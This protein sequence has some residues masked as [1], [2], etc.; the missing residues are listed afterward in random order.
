[1]VGSE[2]TRNQDVSDCWKKM[3]NSKA[4]GGMGFR[5]LQAFNLAMLAKQ[6]WRILSN[7]NS[8]VARVLKDRYVPMSYVLNA[9]LG[10]SLSYSWR[11]I[12][13]HHS[14]LEVIR[15]GTRWRVG[16][17]KLIHIW[18]DKWLPTPSTYKVISPPNNNPEFPMVS[19][20]ID[21]TTKWWKVDMLRATFLLF[22]AKTILR[23][24]LS[25]N[26]PEDKII[27]LGNSCG[28]FTVK[29][30]YH[31]AHKL[32]EAKDEG[33]C[34]SRDPY[35]PLWKKL[36]HLN[37][38]AKVKIFA[39]RVCVNELPTKENINIRGINNSKDCPIYGIKPENTTHA[40]LNC[41]FTTFVW[42][43]W[44]ENPLS[45]QNDELTF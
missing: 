2:A 31:I 1:M 40:L 24:P 33:E 11:S 23:I 45:T 32:V 15:K 9:K 35:K 21:P 28:K 37:I 13:K 19:S 7:P 10:N 14:S 44:L 5:N 27:W 43:M 6:V 3:C 34:S 12:H 42:K 36:W 25:H 22:E 20:L 26:L 8:L 38:P 18:E 29:G 4:K 16:N 41:E 39:W 17:G 30:A